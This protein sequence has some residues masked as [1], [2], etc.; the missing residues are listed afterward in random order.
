MRVYTED[1][2]TNLLYSQLIYE[3]NLVPNSK[4][5]I[6]EIMDVILISRILI[7]DCFSKKHSENKK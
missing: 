2:A 4:S 6:V 7:V 3:N 1:N 5:R